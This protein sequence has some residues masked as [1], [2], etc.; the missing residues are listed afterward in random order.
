MTPVVHVGF[1][2]APKRQKLRALLSST[3]LVNNQ[4]QKGSQPHLVT[5]ELPMLLLLL[6][7]LAGPQ[8]RP[9]HI[10]EAT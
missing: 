7:P 10:R 1:C 8:Q 9:R 3:G 4:S 2:I 6:P 5:P